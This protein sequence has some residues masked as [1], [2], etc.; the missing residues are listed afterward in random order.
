MYHWLG[1][2][3]I[4]R[5]YLDVIAFIE[6]LS[7]YIVNNPCSDLYGLS[8]WSIQYWLHLNKL[9]ANRECQQWHNSINRSFLFNFHIVFITH[10]ES[11][12]LCA[13]YSAFESKF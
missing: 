7:T 12:Q 10:Y 13:F 1:K 2:I 6:L 5:Q 8:L 9:C 4:V 3:V 11:N